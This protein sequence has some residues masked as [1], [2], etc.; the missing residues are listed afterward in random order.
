[1]QKNSMRGA[2]K[3][4]IAFPQIG[5]AVEKLRN[6][7]VKLPIEADARPLI[8]NN[9]NDEYAKSFGIDEGDTV[10]VDRAETALDGDLVIIIANG[11]HSLDT[12]N[13]GDPF[14]DNRGKVVGVVL[15]CFKQYERVKGGVQ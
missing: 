8:F 2:S 3:N 14:Y 5:A 7:T 9:S 13:T 1:M 15:G 11:V 6:K 4:I 10:Y 12:F